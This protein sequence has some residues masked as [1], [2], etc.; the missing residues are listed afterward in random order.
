MK[1]KTL[2]LL[3]GAGGSLLIASQANAG[4]TGIAATSTAVDT[5]GY[6]NDSGIV[7][8]I[9]IYAV[10]DGM[11]GAG[12]NILAVAGTPSE[13][14]NWTV[15]GG[16][17]LY[18]ATLGA[19]VPL[20][21]ALQGVIPSTAADT[22]VV[23]GAFDDSAGL[24]LTPG[25]PAFGASSL[26]VTSGAWAT[27]PGS[28]REVTQNNG[29]GLENSVLIGQFTLVGG[30]GLLLRGGQISGNSGGAAFSY[31]LSSE[32]DDGGLNGGVGLFIPTVPAPG[33]L[34]LL[35]VAGLVGGRRR[36]RS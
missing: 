12:D 19:D 16:G 34:A 30:T 8:V 20:S 6:T 33:A 32:T 18:Q 21:T 29:A 24:T 28:G 7:Q 35:G 26:F 1:V 36:R 23:I 17:T 2:A 13:N 3:A 25:F 14:L 27:T 4:F 22:A 5:T 31:A 9:R 11:G 15:E 10:F